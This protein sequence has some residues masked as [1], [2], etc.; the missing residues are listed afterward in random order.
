MNALLSLWGMRP[1]RRFARAFVFWV[2]SAVGTAGVFE[3][4]T[5]PTASGGSIEADRT[6][7]GHS[8]LIDEDDPCPPWANYRCLI[9]GCS[10]RWICTLSPCTS[11]CSLCDDYGLFKGCCI[12]CTTVPG[13]TAYCRPGVPNYCTILDQY[14]SAARGWNP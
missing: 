10:N 4:R 12:A 5:V 1:A 8:D 13:P 11:C 2:V 3:A 6:R 14:G 7:I 9:S